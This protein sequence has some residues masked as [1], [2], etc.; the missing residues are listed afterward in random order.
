MK[1]WTK[2]FWFKYLPLN[3]QIGIKLR[4]IQRESQ[5]VWTDY[6]MITQIGQLNDRKIVQSTQSYCTKMTHDTRS[7]LIRKKFCWNN[8]KIQ[9]VNKKQE[10]IFFGGKKITIC[11]RS[12]NITK[13]EENSQ[14][15]KTILSPR[16]DKTK[17]CEIMISVS[18]L[19]CAWYLRVYSMYLNC[20]FLFR[21]R[22]WMI[23]N[24]HS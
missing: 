2:H 13:G 24:L 7:L 9:G 12:K 14:S 10:L 8:P 23:R 22:T 1:H 5:K 3:F 21:L 4:H 16:W 19:G 18:E 15:R 6:E 11:M 20:V 17:N